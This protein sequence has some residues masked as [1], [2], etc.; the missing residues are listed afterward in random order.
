MKVRTRPDAD[1][2]VLV[3][4]L[5]VPTGT[6]WIEVGGRKLRPVS[7]NPQRIAVI[8]DTGCRMKAGI[9]LDDGFQDCRDPNAWQFAEVAQRVAEWQP[10]LIIQLGD[11]IYREQKCPDGCSL[12]QG[13]VFLS[14]GVRMR[15][16]NEEFFNPA[17]PMLEAAPLVLVRGDHEKCSRAGRGYFRFLDPQSLGQQCADFSAPYSLDFEGLQLIVMDTVQAEDTEQKLSPEVVINRYARD[18]ERAAELATGASWLLSHRPIWSLRPKRALSRSE[19]NGDP[20]E[21]WVGEAACLN[22]QFPDAA[23]LTVESLNATVQA[24]L[25]ASNLNGTLPSEVEVVLASHV[26]VSE[27]LSFSGGRPPEFTIGN[28]GTKM[29]PTVTDGLLEVPIDSQ[30]ATN[31]TMLEA[32]HGFFGFTP[33]PSGGWRA[34]VLD[35][36]GETIASCSI[37]DKQA[38]CQSR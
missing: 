4:E 2:D 28:G 23:G 20:K 27:V 6:R 11:Y 8:G 30:T 13:L 32:V 15:I 1:F 26:H 10:D 21:N 14:P 7:R 25:H 33:H 17:Q 38:L 29:L 22:Q 24:A 5:L 9:H 12:C 19:A 37:N 31:A 34:E 18:F 3:C 35:V 16:W 36:R